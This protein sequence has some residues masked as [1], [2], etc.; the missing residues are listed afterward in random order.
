MITKAIHGETKRGETAYLYTLSV[1]QFSATISTF[2]GTVVAIN[3]PDRAGTIDNVVLSYGS[4]KEYE[5]NSTYF[6]AIVGR[7]ANRIRNAQFSL[8][9]K[10][11]TLDKNNGGK[12]TLH[13]GFD[14]FNH[15][16]FRATEEDD[17]KNPTLHLTLNSIDNDMG[18]PGQVEL[19]VDYTLSDTGD[20]IIKYRATCDKKT[21]LNLTNH[22][23]FNLRCSDTILDH[24]LYLDCDRYLLVDED[25][26]PTGVVASVASTPYDFTTMKKIAKDID[27]L[28]GYDT[29]MIAKE[30]NDLSTPLA[31]VKE[32]ESGRV[33]KVYTTLEAV[34]FYTGNFLNGSDVAKDGT[35]YEKHYGFCLETQHYPDAVNH[36][37]FPSSIYDVDK[38]F[39]HTTIYSFSTF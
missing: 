33:M 21:P 20:F 8:D 32:H 29:C 19:H 23:Y 1:G 2:G 22:S 38:E 18:F 12:H 24:E 25:L 34:Q 35:P 39:V 15:R 28:G 30:G 13:S 6:G 10:T 17:Q 37:N 27:E 36:E 16:I 31:I 5:E 26:T 14:G 11:Y 4:L 9:G 7:Y 3:V